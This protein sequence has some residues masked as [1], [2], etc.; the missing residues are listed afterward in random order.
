MGDRRPRPFHERFDIEVGADEAKQRFM[1]RVSNLIFSVAADAMDFRDYI[2]AL[3]VAASDLGDRYLP[4]YSLDFYVRDDFRRCLSVL[5]S[6]YGAADGYKFQQYISDTLVDLIEDSETDLGIDWQPPIFV[7]TGARLLDDRL[8][9]DPL[10]WLSDP[11]YQ[12]VYDAFAKG[13][14]HFLR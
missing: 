13:L 10:D 14:S 12:T 2:Y 6:L 8:V 9:N 5:E 1:N 11:K 3:K 4:Q 7:P